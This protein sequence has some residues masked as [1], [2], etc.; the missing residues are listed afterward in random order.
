MYQQLTFIPK[1]TEEVFF[2]L[3]EKIANQSRKAQKSQ[4]AQIGAIR[5]ELNELKD[6][7]EELNF[8]KQ[9]ICKPSELLKIA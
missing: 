5:K 1:T 6:V 4:F 3:A 2:D 8:L 7:R 9:M